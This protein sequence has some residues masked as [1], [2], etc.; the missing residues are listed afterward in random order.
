[1]PKSKIHGKLGSVN[2]MNFGRNHH[3]WEYG[4]IRR[5]QRGAEHQLTSIYN[6]PARA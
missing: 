6:C 2:A 3:I 1:M 5:P 4:V